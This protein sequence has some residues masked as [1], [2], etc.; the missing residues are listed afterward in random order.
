MDKKKIATAL[1]AVNAVIA[2]QKQ[3]AEITAVPD[4][5]NMQGI[6]KPESLLNIWGLSGRQQQMLFRA[7]MQL[8]IYK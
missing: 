6:K 3:E 4:I 5:K 8:R 2:T 7:N 1:A